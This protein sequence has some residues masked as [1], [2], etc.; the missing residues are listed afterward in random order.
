M[1]KGEQLSRARE[2]LGS[3]CRGAIK[4]RSGIAMQ[5]MTNTI[6]AQSKVRVG[7]D[8]RA[9]ARYVVKTTRGP[10]SVVLKKN[11]KFPLTPHHVNRMGSDLDANI[12]ARARKYEKPR[13]LLRLAM[14]G[15]A[16]AYMA[17][18]EAVSSP[19][20]LPIYRRL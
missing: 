20:R 12:S 16:L 17:D 7:F 19:S 10:A 13:Y 14:R 4:K 2:K 6:A 5:F 3:R 15:T 11:K 9:I 8:A 1:P 18:Q